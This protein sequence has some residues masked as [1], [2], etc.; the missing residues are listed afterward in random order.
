M[1]KKLILLLPLTFMA[2]SFAEENAGN[3][4]E[5]SKVVITQVIDGANVC[6]R[7]SNH[8]SFHCL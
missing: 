3:K 7:G 8:L 5:E 2:V 6:G 4:A 1:M